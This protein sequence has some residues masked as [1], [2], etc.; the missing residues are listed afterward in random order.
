MKEDTSPVPDEVIMAYEVKHID[1]HAKINVKMSKVVDGVECTGIINTTPG[2]IIFNEA[3]PQDLG[4]IDRSKPENQFKLEIDFLVNKKNLG[5]LIEKCYLVHGP[6]ETSVMLDLI[7]AKGYHYSSISA[8]TVSTSDMIVPEAKKALLEEAENAVEK[9]EKMY[10]R[11]LI[12]NDERYERVIEKWTKTTDA[13][14]D[15]LMESLDKFN[16]IF[17][18]ADSG[19]RGSK[20]QIK[21]L[22]GM[23][24]LMANPSGK[25][26]ELP[27]KASF[28]EGLDVLQFFIS[29]H[30][31]RKGNA[32]TALKT[33][34]SGYLTRRLG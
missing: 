6:T 32:D 7:K 30:G 5:T 15:A 8:I 18:M 9:I 29:T 26:I 13:V 1:L 17:M 24:G 3:I 19:A 28:R 21:Q 2:L 34:D 31:A 22:A 16:P 10:R 23:R 27:I 33:A 11:G 14:A 25:I 12:S 20:S 4:F